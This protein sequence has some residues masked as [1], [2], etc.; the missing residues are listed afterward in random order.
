MLDATAFR[1]EL[2]AFAR[3]RLG[4]RP[5]VADDVVQDAYLHLLDRAR[6]GTAPDY[7][8]GWLYAVVRTRCAEEGF[9]RAPGPARDL[10]E[11]P[12]TGL[13]PE[14]TV[15]AAAEGRWMLEQIAALPANERDAV[16]AHLTGVPG[17]AADQGRRSANAVHQAL[18]RGRA[19]LRQAHRAA[20]AGLVLPVQWR[21]SILRRAPG[22]AIAPSAL[23]GSAG[24]ARAAVIGGTA[25]VTSL[26]AVS[27]IHVVQHLAG[28]THSTRSGI[29]EISRSEASGDSRTLGVSLLAGGL[30][31][32][33]RAE[34][35]AL[36]GHRVPT[37]PSAGSANRLQ[38]PASRSSDGGPPN[39]AG[40]PND[41]SSSSDSVVE[42]GGP[43]AASQS[44]PTD[45]TSGSGDATQSNPPTSTDITSTSGD[46]TA[47]ETAST[48]GTGATGP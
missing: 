35:R 20:W 38:D 9:A 8:R 19:R 6:A 42:G 17:T 11:V 21:W 16:V 44:Q 31:G 30:Q 36:A 41:A 15:I 12:A 24:V 39:S 13:G 4:N 14:D 47:S 22:S 33:R 2:V 29:G 10:D 18:F 1:P 25:L 5:E 32:S 7:P 48:P 40:A 34:L 37:D 28:G 23:N 43:A 27:G 3:R 46:V 45:T 26:G